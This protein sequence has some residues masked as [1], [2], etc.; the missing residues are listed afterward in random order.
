MSE[1]PCEN[2]LTRVPLVNWI[3]NFSRRSVRFFDFVTRSVGRTIELGRCTI[4][5]SKIAIDTRY[6][7]QFLSHIRGR[8]FRIEYLRGNPTLDNLLIRPARSPLWIYICFQTVSG[9]R[10][11]HCT[12]Y[13]YCFPQGSYF[14]FYSSALFFSGSSLKAQFAVRMLAFL[15]LITLISGSIK[16]KIHWF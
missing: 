2:W 11:L 15:M 4:Y 6:D 8:K 1:L 13:N 12:I 16:L 3:P 10:C 9:V 7:I 14:V 5:A